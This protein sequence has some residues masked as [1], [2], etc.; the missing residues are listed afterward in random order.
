MSNVLATEEQRR[1]RFC[2]A[3]AAATI[4]SSGLPW[5]MSMSWLTA[6]D[7]AR[8][9]RNDLMMNAQN[10]LQEWEYAYSFRHMSW[11]GGGRGGGGGGGVLLV[12]A[13]EKTVDP[14]HA[15]V[16]VCVTPTS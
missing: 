14:T 4:G 11:F 5:S 13:A 7:C 16:Q 2:P 15:G 10:A 1:G 8:L 9:L 6:V 3:A 12:A